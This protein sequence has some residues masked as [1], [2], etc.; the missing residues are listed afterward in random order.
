VSGS[1]RGLWVI[2]GALLV[3]DA[4]LLLMLIFR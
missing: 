3:V 4:T 2:F 1:L